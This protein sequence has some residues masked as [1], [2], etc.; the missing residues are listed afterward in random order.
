MTKDGPVDT[1]DRPNLNDQRMRALLS[2]R[3]EIKPAKACPY[4]EG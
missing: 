3:K 4:Q 1:R 2:E